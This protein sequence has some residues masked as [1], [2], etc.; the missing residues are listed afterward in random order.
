MKDSIKCPTKR[1]V[2]DYN[3]FEVGVRVWVCWLLLCDTSFLAA[4]AA[5]YQTL[6]VSDSRTDWLP[7]F[8]HKTWILRHE[9]HETFEKSDVK[10]KKDKQRKRQKDKKTKRQN[11][12]MRKRQKQRK[13]KEKRQRPKREFHIAMSGQ[14]CTL[15]MFLICLVIP[16]LVILFFVNI[17]EIIKTW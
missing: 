4:L 12:K 11:D 15:A 16:L 6:V 3:I 13:N 9:T 2:S 7:L 17:D 14:F 5:L 8:R 1:E 10:T